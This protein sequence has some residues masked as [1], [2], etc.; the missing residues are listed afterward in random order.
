MTECTE[1]GYFIR[2]NEI[3]TCLMKNDF[4]IVGD[5]TIFP[6]NCKDFYN[7]DDVE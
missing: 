4:Q 7:G 3:A 6:K 2:Y 1:C 5:C